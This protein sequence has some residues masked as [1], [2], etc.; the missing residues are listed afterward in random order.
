[1]VSSSWP[2]RTHQHLDAAALGR[3]PDGVGQQARDHLAQP[4]GVALDRSA[5]R[6]EK[7]EQT[8]R[9]GID[10]RLR[11]LD[12]GAHQRRHVERPRDRGGCGPRAPGRRRSSRRAAP[13]AARAL[14]AIA[15]RPRA[16]WPRRHASAAAPWT[17][18][19]LRPSGVRSACDEA[20]DE[21][22]LE[23]QRP[24]RL[25]G[26]RR[27]AGIGPGGDLAV[28]PDPAET[29]PGERHRLRQ[30]REAA[31]RRPAQ[32][33]SFAS[34]A[35]A[36]TDSIRAAA[37]SGSRQRPRGGGRA[38]PDPGPRVP[39]RQAEEREKAQ[40]ARLGPAGVVGD[41]QRVGACFERGLQQRLRPA[42]AG[43]DESTSVLTEAGPSSR[44]GKSS[45]CGALAWREMEPQDTR[46]RPGAL[47]HFVRSRADRRMPRAATS[48]PK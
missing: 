36:C 35:E 18:R 9:P 16:T 46:P 38:P 28:A 23:A 39:R 40:V 12:G 1:M 19:A 37:A 7:R 24:S 10:R 11:R 27:R 3:E 14:R 43:A 25:G 29:T 44:W 34:S 5:E 4:A 15:S 30:A 17:S 22:V 42:S 2:P 8:Q 47:V 31:F 6:L 32:R 21:L 48:A 26:R 20:G 33:A 41:E 45:V 13:P